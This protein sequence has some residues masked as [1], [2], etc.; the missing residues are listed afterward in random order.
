[1]NSSFLYPTINM[2]VFDVP[3]P[4][5][6]NPFEYLDV[7]YGKTWKTPIDKNFHTKD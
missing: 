2:N 3:C 7:V 5:P 6:K 4:I 1:M